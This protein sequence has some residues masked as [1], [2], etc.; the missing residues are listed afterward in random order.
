MDRSTLDILPFDDLKKRKLTDF[1][2]SIV[3][4]QTKCIDIFFDYYERLRAAQ[5]LTTMPKSSQNQYISY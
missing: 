4:D 1:G 2:L 5:A 3:K